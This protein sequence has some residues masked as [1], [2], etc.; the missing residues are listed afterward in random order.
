MTDPLSLALA[1]ALMLVAIVTTR[2]LPK[3]RQRVDV[4][5]CDAASVGDIRTI[6][7]LLADGVSENSADEDG[8]TALHAAA[9]SGQEGTVRVLLEAN[10]DPD[11]QDVS[12][13]TALMNAVLASGEMDQGDTHPIFLKIVDL[14]LE[15][16]ADVE[17]EDGDGLTARDHAEAYGLVDIVARLDES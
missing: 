17:I 12:G 2:P 11:A 9:F 15:A 10:A 14:L 13:M 3:R 1:S 4:A 16:G 6:K 5:L 7:R 8:M